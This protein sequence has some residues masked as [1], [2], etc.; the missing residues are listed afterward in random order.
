MRDFAFVT[1]PDGSVV[2]HVFIRTQEANQIMENDT[3]TNP[4]L[5][6][7]RDK[8]HNASIDTLTNQLKQLETD[9]KIAHTALDNKTNEHDIT[10][11]VLRLKLEGALGT[12]HT[13]EEPER[14]SPTML[15]A[16]DISD[17]GIDSYKDEPVRKMS[18]EDT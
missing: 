13:D 17:L 2:R 15:S 5:D 14:M 7:Y 11:D 1:Q 18:H 12:L 4:E 6:K 16:E 10:K 8:Q 3:M 9:V